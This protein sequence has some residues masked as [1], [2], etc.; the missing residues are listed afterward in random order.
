M[1]SHELFDVVNKCVDELD[2]VSARKVMEENRDV[3][4]RSKHRLHQNAQ[5]LFAFVMNRDADNEVLSQKEVNVIQAINK[6]ASSFDIRAFKLMVKDK[7]ALICKKDT[8]TYLNADAKALLEC[9]HV[10]CVTE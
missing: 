7:A 9:M 8:L 2:F 10:V 1:N 6:Y 4:K 3:L 5:D